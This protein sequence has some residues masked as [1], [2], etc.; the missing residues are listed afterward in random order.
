MYSMQDYWFS[1]NTDET[2][3]FSRVHNAEYVLLKAVT[4]SP[5]L[6]LNR[7]L[8]LKNNF[9]SSNLHLNTPDSR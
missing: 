3:T 6:Y 5:L 4:D 2:N 9:R 8:R 7:I 1:Y